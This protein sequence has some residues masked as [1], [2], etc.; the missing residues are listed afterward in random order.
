MMYGN[1]LRNILPKVAAVCVNLRN[2]KLFE[3][4][5][6]DGA[7]AGLFLGRAGGQLSGIGD[8]GF[9][10]ELIDTGFVEFQHGVL[11]FIGR[12]LTQASAPAFVFVD[13]SEQTA[14][15]EHADPGEQDVQQ[16]VGHGQQEQEL[17]DLVHLLVGGFLGSG[18]GGHDDGAAGGQR[19]NGG[20]EGGGGD[21]GNQLHVVYAAAEGPQDV[22][23]HLEHGGHD[24]AGGGT[25]PGQNAGGGGQDGGCGAGAHQLLQQVGDHVDAAHHVNDG[26]QHAHAADEDQSAPGDA[27]DGLL[28]IRALEQ[29][30][31]CRHDESSEAGV[32]LEADAEDY[33]HHDGADGDPL[34]PVELGNVLQLQGV[35]CLDLVAL[36][37]DVEQQR[38]DK[39][40][41]QGRHKEVQA[42]EAQPV[43]DVGVGHV[44]DQVVGELQTQLTRQ[45]QRRGTAGVGAKLGK[46]CG[47]DGV[48]LH[49]KGQIHREGGHQDAGGNMAGAD[50][51]DEGGEEEHQNGDQDG[52]LA[53]QGNDL[54]GEEVQ[55]AV[56]G[57]HA[58]EEGDAHQCD[59]HVAV[60]GL[61][62]VLGSDAG[63][64][65]QN[66]GRADGQEAQVDLL[67]EADGNDHGQNHQRNNRQGGGGTGGTAFFAGVAALV[68]GG[69]DLAGPFV[70]RGFLHAGGQHFSGRGVAGLFRGLRSSHDFGGFAQGDH[71]FLRCRS[72]S[73]CVS[74]KYAGDQSCQ[75]Q[76]NQ[77]QYAQPR[78]FFRLQ[79]HF[80]SSL[81]LQ[82]DPGCALHQ[83][84]CGTEAEGVVDDGAGAVFPVVHATLQDAAGVADADELGVHVGGQNLRHN[85]AGNH[86]RCGGAHGAGHGV[87]GMGLLHG[88]HPGEQV[89]LLLF[90]FLAVAV[91][92]VLSLGNKGHLGDARG[93]PGG[94]GVVL[95]QTQ[96]HGGQTA[97]LFQQIQLFRVGVQ[98][99]GELPAAEPQILRTGEDQRVGGIHDGD[100]HRTV[101]GNLQNVHSAAGGQQA[102]SQGAGGVHKLQLDGGSGARDT[103][104]VEVA[105]IGHLALGGLHHGL[106][107]FIGVCVV[108][109]NGSLAVLGL[110]Q[111]LFNGKGAHA[112][113][114][115]AAVALVA[116]QGL[117]HGNL[118][119]GVVHIG[120]RPGGLPD[121]G[122]LGGHGLGAAQ[123][124]DLLAV[125]AAHEPEQDGLPGALIFGKI[126]LENVDALA[127]AAAKNGNGKFFDFFH[128]LP[129]F[130]DVPCYGWDLKLRAFSLWLYLIT[131]LL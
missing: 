130:P 126:G 50:G 75:H 92:V 16:N 29:D 72:L 62:D 37:E 36:G 122:D 46:E 18:V 119:E 52:A 100:L 121:D 39:A 110:H 125:R 117:V 54:L 84:V 61:G 95:D 118:C 9:A 40:G 32:H 86:S 2:E 124:V 131:F 24:H 60:K 6:N 102:L 93:V 71:G 66:E 59:E 31:D 99:V 65:G 91:D 33:H 87:A 56:L 41:D 106:D 3:G 83:E 20:C 90:D 28:F 12:G 79:F 1:D 88:H 51:G 30:Q 26:D 23:Q 68:D 111:A 101:P 13:D 38:K 63:H 11:L 25:D 15:P 58:K 82:G 48:D 108:D 97:N 73:G 4:W 128:K 17:E 34:L 76:Q 55:G 69:A 89:D 107:D 8:D 44:G 81:S 21:G 67:D 14:Q 115:V 53:Y 103:G 43:H 120:V 64:H 109:T 123:A 96:L 78:R 35:V 19:G 10:V 112:G 98:L 42:A 74:G 80:I 22:G 129:S 57:G 113:G 49:L 7:L 77:Q 94:A 104:N 27:L 5:I 105:L 45:G 116:D 114:D 85:G 47:G 127:G 70:G